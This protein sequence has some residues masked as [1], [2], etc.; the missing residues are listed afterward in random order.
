MAKNMVPRNRRNYSNR[1]TNAKYCACNCEK[2]SSYDFSPNYEASERPI[3]RKESREIYKDLNYKLQEHDQDALRRVRNMRS[4]FFAGLDPRRRQEVAEAGMIQED[5]NAIANLSP[6][7]IN[8][9]YPREGF[10]STPYLDD[11]TN[12]EIY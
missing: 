8:R 12:D 10:Y 6:R 3:N 9:E 4:A 7:F 2:N 5:E 11:I 1:T